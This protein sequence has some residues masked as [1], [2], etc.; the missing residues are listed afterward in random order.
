MLPLVGQVATEFNNWLVPRFGDGFE[1]RPDLDAVPAL[2]IRR[3]RQWDKL[4]RADFLT[5]NEKRQAA[6]SGAIAGSAW[7]E[8]R[9]RKQARIFSGELVASMLFHS[10]TG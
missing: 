9:I 8:S 2:G 7:M 4:T 10:V 1:L 6:G 5:I 3:E